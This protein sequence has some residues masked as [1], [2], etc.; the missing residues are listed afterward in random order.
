M[1]WSSTAC[2]CS[3]ASSSPQ[4]HSPT[5]F[6]L[7]IVQPG[8]KY[9]LASSFLPPEYN[10]VLSWA[11]LPVLLDL[12]A[13]KQQSHAGPREVRGRGLTPELAWNW[14]LLDTLLWNANHKSHSILALFSPLSALVLKNA[15]ELP[16]TK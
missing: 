2:G 3:E 11:E 6:S 4:L 9:L 15:T 5:L 12:R 1:L 10:Q 8:A 13:S 16:A 14:L 7:A